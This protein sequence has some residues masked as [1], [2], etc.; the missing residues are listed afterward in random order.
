ML[1]FRCEGFVAKSG[2]EGID[3][4]RM[5]VAQGEGAEAAVPGAQ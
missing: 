3:D 4:R 2:A 1:A 5:L